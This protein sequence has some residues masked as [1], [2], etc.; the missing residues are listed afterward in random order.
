MKRDGEIE[1][2]V[3]AESQTVNCVCR[4]ILKRLCREKK[5][6]QRDREYV[7]RQRLCRETECMQRDR[8]YAERQRL[9]RET[10]SMQRDREYA[11]R[12]RLVCRES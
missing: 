10:E 2:C 12:Q 6:M 5:S 8:E 4:G 11:E 7:E 3:C 9:C 1:D